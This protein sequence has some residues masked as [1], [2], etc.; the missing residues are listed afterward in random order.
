[1]T[2]KETKD[3]AKEDGKE[4][5]DSDNTWYF[6]LEKRRRLTTRKRV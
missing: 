2:D 5:A 4:S 3:Y 1:M 6:D